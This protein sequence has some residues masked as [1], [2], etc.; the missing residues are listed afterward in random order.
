RSASPQEKFYVNLCGVS[1]IDGAGKILLKEM[2]R[3]GSQLIAEGCLNQAIVKEIVGEERNG[4]RIE[5]SA[6]KKTPIIFYVALFS[7]YLGASGLH[8]QSSRPQDIPVA[9][10]PLKL[11][12][13]KAVALALKQNTT[14]QIAVLQAA[15]SVQDKNIAR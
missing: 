15:E 9:G 8:A 1:F 11:T 14:A 7:L 13:D 2:Y 10:Q 3:E 12:L 5:S 6:G 4:S